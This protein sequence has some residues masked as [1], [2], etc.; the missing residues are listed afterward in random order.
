MISGVYFQVFNERDSLQLDFKWSRDF[1][2]AL[3]CR[4][5]QAFAEALKINKSIA[6]IDLHENNIGAEGAKAWCGVGSAE[7]SLNAAA[8]YDFMSSASCDSDKF[9]WLGGAAISSFNFVRELSNMYCSCCARLA[10][11]CGPSFKSER[12]TCFGYVSF[13]LAISQRHRRDIAC[14]IAL[15]TGS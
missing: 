9:G 15:S 11:N 3:I 1:S 2:D 10:R 12:L 4:C 7:N 6:T 13:V 14:C 5:L 8:C